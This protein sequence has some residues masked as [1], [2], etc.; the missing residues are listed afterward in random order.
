MSKAF[1]TNQQIIPKD[2]GE[3]VL[4]QRPDHN[5]PKW[6]ARIKINGSKR[7]IRKSTGCLD[8]GDAKNIATKLYESLADKFRVTGS[9]N[10]RTFKQVV[11]EW[12]NDLH[13][14]E[15][16]IEEH[17]VRLNNF[18]VKYW[19]DKPI[20]SIKE[21]DLINFIQWRKTD[22][23]TETK[24]GVKRNPSP[25]TIKRD[26]VPLRQVFRFAFGK[27]YTTKLLNF[28]PIQTKKKRRPSFLQEE[29][30]TIKEKLPIWVKQSEG[31]QRHTRDRFY[32]KHFILFIGYSGIRPGTELHSLTWNNLSVEHLDSQHKH[33]LAVR[34]SAGKQGGRT[35]FP[36]ERAL[37]HIE[38]LKQFRIAE[39]DSKKL[40]FNANESIFC[41]EDGR[42]IRSFKKGFNAFLINY[43]LLTDHEG[44]R[45]TPYS[46]RHTY[47]TRMVSSG[48]PHW[49]LAK[50]MGTSVVLLEK[51]YVHDNP[52]DY[53]SRIADYPNPP[54][55]K[56][57]PGFFDKKL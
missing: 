39:L 21:S 31:H 8:L 16:T 6:Q 46:L 29:W 40:P 54:R 53:G 38:E 15:S 20:D 9:T 10:S 1:E 30:E 32:L 19:N 22:G 41:H 26:I 48:A 55:F 28:D 57:A 56:F 3:I 42:P 2:H 12:L 51:Y 47:A 44:A 45:R 13:K 4:Y 25:A 50:N 37:S 17:R 5:T 23:R 49:D 34:V 43:H 33:R 35:T 7:Y 18:P 52:T 27:E 24:A 11:D 36:D 14:S